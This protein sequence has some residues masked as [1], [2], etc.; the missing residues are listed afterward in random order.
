MKFLLTKTTVFQINE[1]FTARKLPAIYTVLD[2][3]TPI[4]LIHDLITM[5]SHCILL[6][7]SLSRY[8]L[9][10]PII[11]ICSIGIDALHNR[12]IL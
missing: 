8:T 1:F 3:I 4:T 12:K 6:V 5:T 10:E 2:P 11:P 9:H 7:L